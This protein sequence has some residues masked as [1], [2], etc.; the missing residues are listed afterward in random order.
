MGSIW[1]NTMDCLYNAKSSLPIL[2]LT[3]ASSWPLCPEIKETYISSDTFFGTVRLMIN[4]MLIPWK[5]EDWLSP[6]ISGNMRQRKHVL[7]GFVIVIPQDK[8]K[9]GLC[10]TI[11]PKDSKIGNREYIGK[12][13]LGFFSPRKYKTLTLILNNVWC[14]NH[15]INAF[16]TTL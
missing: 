8:M 9:L 10:I 14:V 12:S 6:V 1:G 16:S 11:I 7:F 2:L 15:Y 13:I 5:A 3:A 4:T